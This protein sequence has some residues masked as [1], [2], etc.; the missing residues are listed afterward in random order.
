MTDCKLCGNPEGKESHSCM[1]Y[2]KDRVEEL[3]AHLEIEQCYSA[4]INDASSKLIESIDNASPEAYLKAI[5]NL[6]SL[7]QKGE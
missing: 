6:I 1:D 3:E 2:L 7:T 5:R 4:S